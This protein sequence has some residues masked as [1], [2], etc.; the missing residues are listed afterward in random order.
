MIIP[1]KLQN[2]EFR[3]C[4]IK[5]KTKIPFEFNWQ[6][7]TNYPYNSSQIQNWK[8]NLGIV[9]GFGNLVVLDIDNSKFIEEFDNKLN[10]F[11][12]KTGSCG[13]HYYFICGEKFKKNVYILNNNCGELRC[14]RSQVLIPNCIHPNGN[15]YEIY[16][17]VP[18]QKVSKKFLRNLLKEFLNKEEKSTDI[19]R[20]GQDWKDCCE[21]IEAG[22]NFDECNKELMLIGST[23][24]RTGTLDYKLRTYTNAL[25]A[26]KKS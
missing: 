22:Y 12:V 11:S 1:Q 26:V 23:R 15:K 20:S 4:L 17:D 5:T 3:F 2:P 9:C 25:I 8:S 19:S 7:K 14:S 16:N 13:R 21:M 6:T 18:I 10:T 24:W